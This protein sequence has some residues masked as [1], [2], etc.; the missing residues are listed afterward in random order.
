MKSVV[1][2]FV[3]NA[4]WRSWNRIISYDPSTKEFIE[5]G[6][7]HVNG[8]WD[9][10]V[11]ETIRRHRVPLKKGDFM[12]EVL[13]AAVRSAA[14]YRLGAH[15]VNRLISYDYLSNIDFG[16]FDQLEKGHGGVPFARVRKS[17]SLA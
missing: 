2:P 12:A 5:L 11:A 6:L 14:D 9:H 16:K 3:F 7:T 13:P 1:L 15:V 17:L 8:N 10:V 4:H